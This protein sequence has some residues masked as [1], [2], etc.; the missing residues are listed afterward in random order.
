MIPSPKPWTKKVRYP[1]SHHCTTLKKTT[2][3][4]HKLTCRP[5]TEQESLIQ[6][7]H[8]QNTLRNTQ[9]TLAFLTIPLLSAALYLPPLF[10]PATTLL[11]LLSI[12][13]LLASAYILRFLP[14]PWERRAP[15][16]GGKDT[17]T[18]TGIGIEVE[19][20]PLEL[21]L[22]YLNAVLVVLLA[23]V[24]VVGRGKVVT[25]GEGDWFGVLPGVVFGVVIV[26]KV[27][28][29]SVDVGELE[30]LKYGYKG[31]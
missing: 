25:G 4:V 15:L 14:L 17:R 12:T 13:S 11:S 9:Y 21:F 31:A 24:G 28:M 22:V 8:T 27:I 5:K 29:G 23:L 18:A 30:G 6:T 26:A 1:P 19:K 7:L 2:K 16:P 20:G 3:K 10:R